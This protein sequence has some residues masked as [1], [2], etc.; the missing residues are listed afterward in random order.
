MECSIAVAVVFHQ[1][2]V[3]GGA[4]DLVDQGQVGAGFAERRHEW[5]AREAEAVG[6]AIM[7]RSQDHERLFRVGRRERSIGSAI[8]IDAAEGADVRSRDGSEPGL[9]AA[10]PFRSDTR[11]TWT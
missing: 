2:T 8:G 7:R 5:L 4:R 11:A 6:F 10:E 1:R 3:A 9:G